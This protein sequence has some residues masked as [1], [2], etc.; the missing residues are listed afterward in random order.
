MAKWRWTLKYN[1]S[2]PRVPR[3][4]PRGGQW[5]G[6]Y[7]G[8]TGMHATVEKFRG[9]RAY[10]DLKRSEQIHN[11]RE[12]FKALMQ[13]KGFVDAK[14]EIVSSE[15]FDE[16]ASS[17]ATVLYRG[18][19]EGMGGNKQFDAFLYGPQFLGEGISGSGTYTSLSLEE[20]T[21][22]A[23][24]HGNIIRMAIKP[25]AKILDLSNDINPELWGRQENILFDKM[26]ESMFD[27][28]EQGDEKRAYALE[29][30]RDIMRGKYQDAHRGLM[31]DSSAWGLMMGADVISVGGNHYIVLNREAIWVDESPFRNEKKERRLPMFMSPDLSHR[32]AKVSQ[33]LRIVLPAVIWQIVLDSKAQSLKEL[34]KIV[35]RLV[36]DIETIRDEI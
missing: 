9:T 16:I 20:A 13:E 35:Q 25:E 3:G 31:N 19:A 12:V 8:L 36:I 17:G 15:R 10:Q 29:K 34:P 27:A 28:Y 6:G 11:G 22:F 21:Y 5:T 33:T 2:Q 14:P 4:D 7:G 30:L 23:K 1:P 26:R 24:G 32:L 18:I